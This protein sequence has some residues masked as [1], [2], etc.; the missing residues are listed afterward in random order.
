M[1]IYLLNTL[2]IYI[3]RERKRGRENE[4]GRESDRVREND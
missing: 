2:Y 3:E 1:Y 4:R